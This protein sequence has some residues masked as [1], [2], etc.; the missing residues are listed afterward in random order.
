MRNT[1]LKRMQL[2]LVA[3]ACSCYTLNATVT[4]YTKGLSIW[5]DTPNTLQN[6]AIW[7]DGRPDLWQGKKKPISAGDTAT[8][9]DQIG[10][11][12]H[13]LS[14]TVVWVLTLWVQ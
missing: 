9:P 11:L 13:F 12:S 5:F 2:A 3:M 14:V 4:D 8:N 7:Y 1:L 6:R 10:N